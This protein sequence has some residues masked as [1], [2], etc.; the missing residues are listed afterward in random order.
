VD[1][2]GLD[3]VAA[4]QVAR[5]WVLMRNVP[6]EAVAAAKGI[7]I[8]REAAQILKESPADGGS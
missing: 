7:V 1:E 3:E 4:N 8:S 5:C 2:P 6:E